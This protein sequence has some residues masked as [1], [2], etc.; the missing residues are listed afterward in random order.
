MS[1]YKRRSGYK[2]VC[3][4]D[5]TLR[6]ASSGAPPI[7]AAATWARRRSRTFP[8][9]SLPGEAPP[10]GRSAWGRGASVPILAAFPNAP[11]PFPLLLSFPTHLPFP[12]TFP[13]PLPFPYSFRSYSFPPSIHFLLCVPVPT[14]LPYL[15]PFP[16]PFPSP[17]L[18]PVLSPI[19]LPI[20][21][22]FP[23]PLPFL[24]SLL[25]PFPF[26]FPFPI[27]SHSPYVLIPILSFAPIPLCFS[28]IFSRSFT[29]PFHPFSFTLFSHSSFVPF[30]RSFPFPFS[31]PLCSHS[32][33][34]VRSHFPYFPILFIAISFLLLLFVI[35]ITLII[36]LITFYFYY[37]FSHFHYYYLSLSLP[38]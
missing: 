21:F 32:F 28:F 25:F 4:R 35:I 5:F 38:T 10:A 31:F 34:P 33:P 19:P 18:P 29:F 17:F 7:R 22:L 23:Y 27:R 24:F 36:F 8:A 26:R 2:D 6:A 12:F 20:L 13:S 37:Y 30:S 15:F 1:R 14:L 3:V 11:F 16:R 9:D